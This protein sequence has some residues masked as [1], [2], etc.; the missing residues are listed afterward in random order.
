MLDAGVDP[1]RGKG[2]MVSHTAIIPLAD[3]CVEKLLT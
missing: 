2:T 3:N 1:E